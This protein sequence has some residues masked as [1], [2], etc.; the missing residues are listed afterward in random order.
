MQD[1]IKRSQIK[2]NYKLDI[3]LFKKYLKDTVLHFVLLKCTF[4]VVNALIC[5]SMTTYLRFL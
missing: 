5:F 2:V 1:H 4:S 3:L